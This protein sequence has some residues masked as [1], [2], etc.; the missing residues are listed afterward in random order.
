MGHVDESFEA[1]RQ[2]TQKFARSFYFASKAL[3]PETRNA[4]YAV[5][6]FCRSADDAVDLLAERNETAQE[7]LRPYFTYI[8]ALQG[9]PKDKNEA[10][11]K[12]WEAWAATVRRYDI[13]IV[14]FEE[15]LKGLAMDQGRVRIADGQELRLYCYRVAS[16]VGM[17][18]THIFVRNPSAELLQYAEAMGRAMQL[19]N[20]LRDV[21]E[22]WER[23][24]IYLPQSELKAFGVDE[25]SIASRRMTKALR[26]YLRAKV[27]E[28]RGYYR[29]AERGIRELPRGRIRLAVW[30]MR[31]VYG[32]ILD[33]IEEREY[34]IFSSRAYVSFPR[35]IVLAFQAFRAERMS[36]L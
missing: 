13:P 15:L 30:I 32:G 31:Y 36:D 27:F 23:D 6:A 8:S 22:D 9:D 3:D 19:T 17:M 29:E 16:V 24:R 21:A 10:L 11:P 35:K 34:D 7:A 33:V 1:A 25:E 2:I 18:L 14:Y 20:I 26:G 28:A 4:C 12:W 5:Y